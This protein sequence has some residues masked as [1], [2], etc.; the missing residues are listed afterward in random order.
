SEGRTSGL[1]VETQHHGTRVLSMET[2]PHDMRPHTP[3]GPKLGYLFEQIIVA[4][5]EKG[6]ASRKGI[7]IE[8]RIEGSLHIANGIGKRKGHFLYSSRAC[9]AHMIAADADGIPAR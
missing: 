3:C 2:I 1:R 6:K 7:Y 9:F 5:E 4:I 8:S